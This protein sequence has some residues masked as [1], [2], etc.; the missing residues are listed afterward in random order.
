MLYMPAPDSSGLEGEKQLILHNQEQMISFAQ[1][2]AVGLSRAEVRWKVESG[3]WQRVYRGV[4]ATFSGKLTR[5]ARL[6][7]VVLRMGDDA[8]LSHETAARHWGFGRPPTDDEETIHVT[9]PAS[10]NPTRRTDLRG[11]VVH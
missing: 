2:T 8:A 9:V 6:W 5:Q 3:Q 10:S 1:A 4:Y 7:A 11:V